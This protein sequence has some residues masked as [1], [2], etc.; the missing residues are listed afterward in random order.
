MVGGGRNQ[1]RSLPGSCP[2]VEVVDVTIVSYR[3]AAVFR[4]RFVWMRSRVGMCHEIS[5]E[6]PT[7][8]G[9]SRRTPMSPSNLEILA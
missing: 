8:P 1:R 4:S 6:S 3:R 7:F 5:S 9:R 2:V